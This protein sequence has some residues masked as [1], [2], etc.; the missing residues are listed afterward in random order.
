MKPFP[1]PA[2]TTSGFTLIELLTV[3]AIIGILASLSFV[4]IR[5][6]RQAAA[7]A[8]CLSHLRQIGVAFATWSTENKD[9]AIVS[10]ETEGKLW[11]QLVAPYVGGIPGNK[12]WVCTA[13][14]HDPAISTDLWP[15]PPFA[16]FTTPVDYAQNTCAASAPGGIPRN[17]K[18]V[19][20][21]STPLSRIVCLTEGRNTFWN[22]GSWSTQVVPYS[23]A[24]NSGTNVLFLDYHVKTVK[25]ITFQKVWDAT[26]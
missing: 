15:G 12:I 11:M 17:P 18:P 20:S 22:E 23:G 14:R 1:K 5:S 24:H 3:I 7:N 2:S 13:Q 16:G 25:E 10:W 21:A 4:G 19:Y 6:A 8:R 26:L 9:Q